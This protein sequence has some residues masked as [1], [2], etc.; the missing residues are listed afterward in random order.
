MLYV[1]AVLRRFRKI[2]AAEAVRF[3]APREKVKS[4]RMFRFSKS[5]ILSRNA[6]LGVKD[7]LSR[8]KLYLTIVLDHKV[9]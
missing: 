1:K 2:S 7:V 5:R 9:I 8:K 4:A 6:F 3:G